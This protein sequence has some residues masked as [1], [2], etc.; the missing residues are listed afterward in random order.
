V[1]SFRTA[2]EACWAA[3]RRL[4]RSAAISSTVGSADRS[5][6]S[7]RRQ[8]IPA[9]AE[10]SHLRPQVAD[11]LAEHLLRDRPRS[12]RRACTA[13]PTPRFGDLGF[14]RRQLLGLR[15]ALA[16]APSTCAATASRRRSRF[17][18][19]APRASNTATSPTRRPALFRL[20]PRGAVAGARPADGTCGSGASRAPRRRRRPGCNGRTSPGPSGG[21]RGAAPRSAG[22]SLRPARSTTPAPARTTLR[23]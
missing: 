20:A 9:G 22:R 8:V 2:S 18:Y 1:M 23:R 7:S 19:M 10:R 3:S 13:P 17:S 6:A 12:R 11:A 5:S 4:S 14:E 15:C 21:T 16:W